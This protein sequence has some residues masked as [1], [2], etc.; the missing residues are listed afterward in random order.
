MLTE[1]QLD[2]LTEV[3]REGAEEASLACSRWVGRQ[4]QI[5]VQRVELLDM[6]DAVAIIGATEEPLG[7]CVMAITGRLTGA[8]L[9]AF[10]DAS[11]WALTDLLLDHPAGSSTAWDELERSAVLET[12]NIVGCAYLNSLSRLLQQVGEPP[13]LLPSP[14]QFTRDYASAILQSVFLNQVL[15]SDTI[16]LTE[17][18]FHLDGI[19]A[20]WNLLF[21]P[22]SDSIPILQRMLT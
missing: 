1:R 13:E 19:P 22:D 20:S 14:P 16:F 4:P 10:D 5:V 15:S 17:T 9:L 12:T 6:G 2:A 11:G 21:V 7:A 18:Q 8:L 3:L